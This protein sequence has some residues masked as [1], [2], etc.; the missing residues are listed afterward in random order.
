[1]PTSEQDPVTQQQPNTQGQQQAKTQPAQ[2]AVNRQPVPESVSQ[3]T[4]P[5]QDQPAQPIQQNTQVAKPQPV[6]QP[7]SQT[8][9][10]H[11]SQTMVTQQADQQSKQSVTNQAMPQPPNQPV[12]QANQH[13]PTT[14]QQPASQQVSQQTVA[15]VEPQP[16]T[17]ATAGT[18][19]NQANQQGIPNQANSNVPT[20][21]P[22]P[23]TNQSQNTTTK[24]ASTT[25]TEV[26]TV[27]AKKKQFQVQVLQ[28]PPNVPV[29]DLAVAPMNSNVLQNTPVHT[30][31]AHDSSVNTSVP[32]QEVTKVYPVQ[33]VAPS[34]GASPANARGST[35]QQPQKSNA[36]TST[37]NASKEIS[38]LPAKQSSI[39]CATTVAQ[40]TGDKQNTTPTVQ[41]PQT[42]ASSPIQQ[43]QP[44]VVP[45]P[46]SP[47]VG[48]S[49]AA[50]NT[51]VQTGCSQQATS[52]QASIAQE[53]NIET[54]SS[55]ETRDT[56]QENIRVQSPISSHPPIYIPINPGETTKEKN[57]SPQS[58]IDN[59]KSSKFDEI[60]ALTSS[61]ET[62]TSFDKNVIQEQAKKSTE[63]KTIEKSSSDE[64][65][66]EESDGS[67]EKS[68]SR[69]SSDNNSAQDMDRNA[70]P[71]SIGI[72]QAQVENRQN[73]ENW[74][75]QVILCAGDT[76]NVSCRFREVVALHSMGKATGK[77]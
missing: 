72:S 21:F 53:P 6:Q 68:Y 16:L 33:E 43:Q 75:S 39:P 76:Y 24:S 38:S 25:P 4:N 66:F 3:V 57:I 2:Q 61:I 70:M 17:Q 67:S 50:P 49:S 55:T 74:I 62:Q 63:R 54:S 32:V 31:V 77:V 48:R 58:S 23:L 69:Q 41:P 28:E 71:K 56:P 13:T 20:N 29:T 10:Q 26:R 30:N 65:G 18:I 40:G 36:E 47:V 60:M 22:Q 46:A 9:N 64:Q 7:I 11:P 42:R 44:Q 19:P 15:K 12:S 35:T 27:V 73:I 14:N 45:K 59:E 1:M 8:P 52:T 51:S 5:Q 37:E 34:I